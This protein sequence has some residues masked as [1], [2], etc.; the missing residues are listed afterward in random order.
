MEICKLKSM[1][2]LI[3]L[4]TVITISPVTNI[5]AVSPLLVSHTRELK[6]PGAGQN[7]ICH[8]IRKQRIS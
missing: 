4:M 2:I 1:N 3:R 8:A 7:D 6:T 5:T